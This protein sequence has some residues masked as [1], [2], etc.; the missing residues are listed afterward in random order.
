MKKTISN[1][2]KRLMIAVIGVFIGSASVIMN[3]NIAA[4]MHTKEDGTKLWEGAIFHK[5]GDGSEIWIDGDDLGDS[6]SLTHPEKF[7]FSVR[8]KRIER[9]DIET[10]KND[11]QK[12]KTGWCCFF[13][14]KKPGAKEYV[15]FLDDELGANFEKVTTDGYTIMLSGEPVGF[16]FDSQ[17]AKAYISQRAARQGCIVQAYITLLHG[18]GGSYPAAVAIGNAPSLNALASAINRG[19]LRCVLS[20]NYYH[21]DNPNVTAEDLRTLAHD[22]GIIKDIRDERFKALASQVH[23]EEEAEIEQ[24]TLI[25][26][27]LSLK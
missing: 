19:G 9:Q 25:Y 22:G 2:S 16:L 15:R 6:S 23:N 21:G 3:S 8:L 11:F 17:D 5:N 18:L 1:F 27:E 13:C 20:A 14:C 10:L 7:P 12:D 26:F 4:M 24:N